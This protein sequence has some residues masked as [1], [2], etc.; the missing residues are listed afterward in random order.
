MTAV[1]P[2]AVRLSR[3]AE[4]R[5][6][7]LL[8]GQLAVVCVVKLSRDIG[9]DL[10]WISH[11]ALLLAAIG[12]TVRSPLMLT[13]A[14]TCVLVPHAMWLL[15]FAGW[16]A[17]GTFPLGVCG[18]LADADVWTWSATLH[19][20]YLMPLLLFCFARERRVPPT[21]LPLAVAI[22]VSLGLLGRTVLSPA[23]NVNYAWSLLPTVDHP[24]LSWFNALPNSVYLPL[25]TAMVTGLCFLP[26]A[27]RLRAW[28]H[29]TLSHD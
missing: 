27:W 15:D 24:A 11:V 23:R 17:I 8:F 5:L 25:L 4:L 29:Q 13:T 16:M 12:L 26:A 18:Y 20:F 7:W 28:S 3:A 22:F 10:A 1:Q 21:T 9:S 19:H 2:I 6:G 14:L